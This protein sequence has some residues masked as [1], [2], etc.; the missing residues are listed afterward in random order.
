MGYESKYSGAEVEAI[1]DRAGDC[2]TKGESVDFATD[3]TGVVEATHEEFT[4][5]PSA[6]RKSIRDK[7]AVIR[8]IKGNSLVWN[9]HAT[10]KNSGTENGLTFVKE[11]N[12][13]HIYGTVTEAFSY[14]TCALTAYLPQGLKRDGRKYLISMNAP[15]G[16]AY[17]INGYIIKDTKPHFWSAEA[18]SVWYGYISIKIPVGTT[19]DY[20]FSNPQIIDVTQMF[21]AG[22]EPLTV[23]EFYARIPEGVDIHAFNAGELISMNANAIETTGFNQWDEQ[24][25][26]GYINVNNGNLEANDVRIASVNFCSC[27]PNTDYYFK[28][29]GRINV[30]FYDDFRNYIGYL[31]LS[32]NGK[33]T[34]PKKARFFKINTYE[35]YGPTYKNDICINLSHSGVRDGEYE[36]YEKNTLLLPEIAKYF[37]NGMHGIGDVCDEIIDGLAIQRIGE[38]DLGNSD[39]KYDSTRSAFYLRLYNSKTLGKGICLKFTLNNVSAPNLSDGEMSFHNTYYDHSVI[40]KATS[41]TNVTSFKSAMSGVKLY[42]ELAEPIVTEIDDVVDF[43]Y[44]IDDFGTERILSDGASAPFKADIVYQFNAEGRIRD[45][46]RNIDSLEG[47]IQTLYQGEDTTGSIANT[48]KRNTI[49]FDKLIVVPNVDGL[50]KGRDTKA[51]IDTA[52]KNATPFVVDPD[53][54]VIFP[55]KVVARSFEDSNGNA[56]MLAKDIPTEVATATQRV[57]FS[58]MSG[59]VLISPNIMYE[60]NKGIGSSGRFVLPGLFILSNAYDHVW[61]LRFPSIATSSALSYPYTIMWKDGVA[62]TFSETCALEIYLKMTDTEEILGEWRIYKYN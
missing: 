31:P 47:Q 18:D 51:Y 11:G 57:A 40:F 60:F 9:Q 53:K 10:F 16:I 22:N 36:P 56:V 27:L 7:S 30:L 17:G 20:V 25:V 29:Q 21:G 54:N 8:R 6:G 3:L 26:K 52:I 34:T 32:K 12:T 58:D 39:I 43:A 35:E 13:L 38:V 23:D 42:Y 14:D 49:S 50:I 45:N 55:E 62:P 44:A 33:G 59:N 15:D 41:Y 48:I 37:R 2:I 4:Y 46:S 61:M 1:L 24:W 5:R 19:V 28:S